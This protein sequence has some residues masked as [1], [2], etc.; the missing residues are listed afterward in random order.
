MWDVPHGVTSCITL[1]HA[2]RF[3]AKAAPERFGPIAEGLGVVFDD[4]DPGPGAQA[5]AEAVGRFIARFDVPRT[6]SAVGVGHNE[7]RRIAAAV[8]E[9]IN[10]FGAVGRPM[11][12]EEVTA[13]LEAAA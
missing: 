2:M 11:T 6:L 3:M 13:L 9:E 1:P 4:G 10:S 5:C 7:L 12:L 8:H